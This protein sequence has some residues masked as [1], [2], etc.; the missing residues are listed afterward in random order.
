MHLMNE[1]HSYNS[2]AYKNKD[3]GVLMHTF[4]CKYYFLIVI[5]KG[6][7]RDL[8]PGPSEGK[9]ANPVKS[10]FN[11]LLLFMSSSMV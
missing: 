10:F 7:P 6:E 9:L 8:N 3:A 5:L 2:K 4:V 11:Y 1:N